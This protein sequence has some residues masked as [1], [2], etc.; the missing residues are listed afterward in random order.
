M[1]DEIELKLALSETEQRRFLRLALLKR[2]VSRTTESLI[3]IYYDTPDLAL[4]RHGIALRLRRQGRQWLQTVKCAG[5]SAAGL[6]QRPEWETPYRGHFDFSAIDAVPLR[7]W[8]EK[9]KITGRITPVF[10]TN[11][12]RTT[13]RFEPSAGT[14]LLL[15][16]DRGW[17][18]AAGRRESIT[19]L[20][21]ELAAGEVAELFRLARELADMLPLTPALR[22]KA[23]RGYRLFAALPEMPVKAHAVPLSNDMAPALAFRRIAL[24]CLEHLQHNQQ[25][26][27]NREDPEYIHQ[28]RVAARRLRAATRLFREVLPEGFAE[29]LPALHLLMRQLGAARDLDVLQSEI[30][31]P[32]VSALPEEPRLAALAGRVTERHHAA[33]SAALDTL[34]APE[35]GRLLLLALSLL[36]PPT[37]STD[38][39]GATLSR[40]AAARLKR[41]R[42]RMLRLAA[43]ARVDD[44]ASLHALRIGVKRLRYA[45][46]FLSPLLPT[47]RLRKVLPGLIDLQDSLGQLNDLAN[48]GQLLMLCADDEPQLREAV[49]LIGGWHG[50]RH[51][52]LLAAVVKAVAKL[53][54]FPP[55]LDDIAHPAHAA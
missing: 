19:E 46:E 29:T 40:F 23:E 50:P 13:W 25:G 55:P 18:A 33:R 52:M 15:T 11:F 37:S 6:S 16:L 49:S 31:T 21:I 27:L 26:A 12:R 24:V 41:L 36:H 47:S 7:K 17:I 53:R 20:E 54:H 10:E 38:A 1:S 8:L 39:A 44:P 2:A 43:A 14:A 51:K 34:R 45:L 4:Q 30:V 5:S 32:V 28:M 42:R 9:P 3:N 22:S 48:A 35:Y